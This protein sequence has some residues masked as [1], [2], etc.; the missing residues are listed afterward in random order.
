MHN[1]PYDEFGR[2]SYVMWWA[3][4]LVVDTGIHVKV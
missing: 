1:E 2:L 3:Y 4:R